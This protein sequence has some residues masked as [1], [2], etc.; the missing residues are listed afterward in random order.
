M[1]TGLDLDRYRL[2]QEKTKALIRIANNL[3]KL[4]MHYEVQ[5]EIM[6]NRNNI[7]IEIAKLIRNNNTVSTNQ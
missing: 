2:E 5:R 4:N 7:L 3:E 1:T 6:Q